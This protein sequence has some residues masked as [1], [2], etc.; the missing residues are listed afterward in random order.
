MFSPD[1]L[2]YMC[3]AVLEEEK[4]EQRREIAAKEKLLGIF[5]GNPSKAENFIYEFAAYFIAHDNE[6]VLASPVARVVLT[7]SRVKGEEVDQWVDQ[8]LQ[9]LGLQD[10]QD[11]RVGSAFVEAFFKQYVPKGRWQSTARIEMKWPY[12]DEYISDFEKAHVH[13]K[14]LLKGIDQAQWFIKGLAGSVKRAMMDKFQT[15]EKVK[16]QASHIIE[17][18]KLL[19]W[20]YKERSNTWT[21]AQG[22]PQKIL[23]PMN[24]RKPVSHA[25]TCEEQKRLKKVW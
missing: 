7:L 9:W 16:K 10:Q 20:A 3:K 17:I 1:V 12:I 19:H 4:E 14:Q 24:L 13:S 6:P 18:Q 25:P 8:Q 2:R 15:Y 23:Q 5:E 22:Q 21:N 11:L